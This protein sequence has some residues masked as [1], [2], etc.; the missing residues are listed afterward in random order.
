MVLHWTQPDGSGEKSVGSRNALM[1][2]EEIDAKAG[3]DAMTDTRGS[4]NAM[5]KEEGEDLEPR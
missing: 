1:D 5:Q 2:K 4:M 3:L